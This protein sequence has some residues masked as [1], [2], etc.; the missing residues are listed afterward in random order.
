M[1]APVTPLVEKDKRSPSAARLLVGHGDYDFAVSR[2]YCAMFY[3]A[4][5]VLLPRGM[6]FPKHGAVIA[7]FGQHFVKPGDLPVQLHEALRMAFDERNIGDY[8]FETS[9]PR[10]RAELLLTRAQEFVD[11]VEA[12]LCEEGGRGKQ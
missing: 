4:E 10:E 9:Y 2:A 5:A 8:G 3:L 11:T 1:K 7:A 12:Y 6:A